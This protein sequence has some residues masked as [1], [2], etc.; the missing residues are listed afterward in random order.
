LRLP[1]KPGD[2][3]ERFI[4]VMPQFSPVVP[5]VVSGFLQRFEINDA[6][7]GATIILTVALA[8]RRSDEKVPIILDIDAYKQQEFS[9]SDEGIWEYLGKLRSLKNRFFFTSL[10]SEAI[11]LYR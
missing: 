3:F 2:D 10:T 6:E 9:P 8:S 7:C 1:Y 11:E 4:T 5:Q